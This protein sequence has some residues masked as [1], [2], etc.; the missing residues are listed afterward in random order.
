MAKK[1]RSRSGGAAARKAL[2]GIE[3]AHKAL[4]LHLRNLRKSMGHPH[5]WGKVKGHPH[6]A[7]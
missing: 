3:K 1:T 7:R 5:T 4:Q 2:A 6:T